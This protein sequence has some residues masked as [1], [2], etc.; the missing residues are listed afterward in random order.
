MKLL[1]GLIL[2]VFLCSSV[3]A[4]DAGLVSLVNTERAFAKMASEKGTREAF[5]YYLAED[6]VIFNPTPIPARPF[7]ESRPASPSLLSWDPSMADCSCDLGFTTGPWEYS[8]KAGEA[9]V[10]FGNFLSLWRKQKDGNWKLV[11]DAGTEN[12]KPD[13][14]PASFSATESKNPAPAHFNV[15]KEKTAVLAADRRLSEIASTRGLG[16]G[17]NDVLL[18]SADARFLRDRLQPITGRDAILKYLKQTPAKLKWDEPKVELSSCGD[19]GYTYGNTEI[20]GTQK[21]TNGVFVRIWRK[22]GKEWKVEVDQVSPVQ[23]PSK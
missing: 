11:L 19:F 5:L 4:A 2:C 6:S 17:L 8:T 7:Y 3:I 22:V 1:P 9:P 16:E 21:T 20:L 18:D 23:T 15:A 10:A 14:P 12:P 13:N